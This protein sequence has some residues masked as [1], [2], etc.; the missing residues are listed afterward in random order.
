MRSTIEDV[1]KKSGLSYVTVSRVIGNSPHVREEN[2]KK[3]LEAIDA[4]G[5]VPNAAARSLVTGKTNVVALLIADL[6]DDFFDSIVKSV[7]EHLLKNG[8]LL[9]LTICHGCEE[10]FRT[11]FL[12][13]H[14]VDGVILMAPNHERYYIDILKEHK[15][16]FV[17]LDNQTIDA[18]TPAILAD[19]IIGGY[20]AANHLL[21]LG[22][23]RI[24]FI[25]ADPH[26][27][28][29]LERQL[30]AG[31][32]LGEAGLEPMA[33]A[34]GGYDQQTGYRVCME[35]YHSGKMPSAIFA[36]DDNIALGVINAAKDAGLRVP[37]DVSVCGYDD[38]NLGRGFT[39]SMTSV[40][41]PVSEMAESAVMQLLSMIE[42]R[43]IRR[44]V[45]KH[46]PRLAIRNSTAQRKGTDCAKKDTSCQN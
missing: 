4:L 21:G 25:G 15:V 24:G 41:Q 40:G 14:R 1:V 42:G 44:G 2:R 27:L 8:Y 22:H 35:W 18:D 32:A 17:V 34:Y 19:N 36:F 12:S 23:T 37:E 16:P 26:G 43:A 46:S 39:P 28:A 20:I 3:V 7:N 29:T 11:S 45:I 9:A 13:Q 33:I 5:Y 6:G 38:S 10:N 31:K 30:G